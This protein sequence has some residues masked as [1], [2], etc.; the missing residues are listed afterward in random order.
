M[1][2]A[3]EAP[4]LRFQDGQSL[5]ESTGRVLVST[6]KDGLISIPASGITGDVNRNGW[7]SL[8]PINTPNST[9]NNNIITFNLTSG[10]CDTIVGAKMRVTLTES[11][12][13][14][15]VRPTNVFGLF[16]RIDV[17][18]MD[19][20]KTVLYSHYPE[21]M[22]SK[23]QFKSVD[24]L[25]QINAGNGLNL[26]TAVYAGE[27]S[28]APGGS[29]VLWLPLQGFPLIGQNPKTWR[30]Q[31]IISA[32]MAATP[33]ISGTGTLAITGLDLF[34]DVRQGPS[35]DSMVLRMRDATNFFDFL[36]NT[37]ISNTLNLTAGMVTDYQI[38]CPTIDAAAVVFGLRSSVAATAGAYRNYSPVGG[39]D[40]N[41]GVIDL[42]D[43]NKNSL[44]G[45]PGSPPSYF[46]FQIP[47][48]LTRGSMCSVVPLYW[49][50]FPL[51][52]G[53]TMKN[54]S[55]SGGVHLT[56]NCY[57]RIQPSATFTTGAYVLTMF[58]FSEERLKMARNGQIRIEE[59]VEH[60][61][62]LQQLGVRPVP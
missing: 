27:S 15:S 11:G 56:N 21:A 5:A 53:Q 14:N 4:L 46:R 50:L 49:F 40:E 42:L 59:H 1:S 3:K 16:Q 26:T 51:D 8:P 31:C 52:F 9:L 19:G 23:L 2:A 55:N 43:P 62:S 54:F 32:Y 17:C 41:T 60:G 35:F 36:Y 13:T 37:P 34:M 47:S 25:S 10:Y 39:A 6:A 12:G 29:M 48:E 38:Q 28:I 61:D 18:Q 57:L 58:I 45:T 20:S 44:T 30:Q 7:F 33:V 22:Y 24:Q